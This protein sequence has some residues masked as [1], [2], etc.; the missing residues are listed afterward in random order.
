M[1]TVQD[2]NEVYTCLLIHLVNDDLDGGVEKNEESSG[3]Y[4]HG[5]VD[6][7]EST[8]ATYLASKDFDQL[9]G[10]MVTTSTLGRWSLEARARRLSGCH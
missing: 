4:C 7:I 1:V 8:H 9:M 6:L 5:E 10:S 2:K 3:H